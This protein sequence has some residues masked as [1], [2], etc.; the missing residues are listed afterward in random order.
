MMKWL[1]SWDGGWWIPSHLCLSEVEPSKTPSTAGTHTAFRAHHRM[2]SRLLNEGGSVVAVHV[3]RRAM[4]VTRPSRSARKRRRIRAPEDDFQRRDE[5]LLRAA[6]MVSNT[7]DWIF[8]FALPVLVL[9]LTG[10]AVS[11]AL[12]YAV[13]FIPFVV[14]GLFSGVVADR[15]DRRKLMIACDVV[16]ALLVTGVG[17]LC[18]TD[19]PAWLVMVA[20]FLLGC[21]RPFSFPA[22]QAL[23]TE[24]V[25][26]ERR[27]SMNAWVQSA[28]GT[29]AMLGPVAG[30]AVVTLLGPTVASFTNATSFTLAALLVS[31]TSVTAAGPR[32]LASLRTA[33]RSLVPDSLAALRLI[34]TD[35][36]MLW[37]TVLLTLSNFTFPAAAA[38]LVYIVAGPD[39]DVPASLAVVSAALGLGAVLGAVAAP[40]LL[41]RFSPGALMAGG[42]AVKALALALPALWPGVGTLT[43][44]WF[45]VGVTTSVF[46][47]PWRTYRQAA[48][49]NEFL[50]RVVGLQRAIPFAAIPVSALVGSWL[51]VEFGPAVLFGVIA[52]VQFFVW[53]GTRFSP[54]GRAESTDAAR[55]HPPAVPRARSTTGKHPMNSH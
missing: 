13:E 7:G 40:A 16:S 48:V 37:A 17:I 22:F 45:V 6:F 26:A 36:S 47:V 33:C 9:Q 30:V 39:G 2:H 5:R 55:G 43:A 53:L 52:A 38:N 3:L 24:R 12:T 10:S 54:L 44:C 49:D 42:M 35:R 28:D 18:L 19:P 23:I 27:A 8:R 32:L 25:A 15:S 29:L 20:A 21:V 31:A 1:K 41:R 51:V 46:I 11:T 14:I 4:R 34:K 50:G